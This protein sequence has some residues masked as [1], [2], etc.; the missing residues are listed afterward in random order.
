MSDWRDPLIVKSTTM[1]KSKYLRQLYKCLTEGKWT[2][3]GRGWPDLAAFRKEKDGRVSFICVE[4]IRKKTYRL[5]RHQRAVMEALARSG[6]ACYIYRCDVGTFEEINFKPPRGVVPPAW[7]E[8]WRKEQ[9]E[10]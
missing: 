9:K 7:E 3:T 1:P 8:Q 4:A 5:R 6:V 2:V 10:R